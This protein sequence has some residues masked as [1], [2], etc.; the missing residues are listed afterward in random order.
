MR[1]V[2]ENG[3]HPG[4]PTRARYTK[5]EFRRSRRALPRPLRSRPCH[6][7][8]ACSSPAA[9]TRRR[10]DGGRAGHAVPGRR[11]KPRPRAAAPRRSCCRRR[12]L[13]PRRCPSLDKAENE[14]D[15]NPGAKRP[16]E[17]KP[18]AEREAAALPAGKA[19][20]PAAAGPVLAKTTEP[21]GQ[22]A[23]VAA[24]QVAATPK[25]AATPPAKSVSLGPPGRRHPRGASSQRRCTAGCRQPP[26]FRFAI[27][28]GHP[29]A[30][31]GGRGRAGTHTLL[32]APPGP[33]PDS[34]KCGYWAQALVAGG[35]GERP[36]HGAGASEA[37][38]ALLAPLEGAIEAPVA[39]VMGS[40]PALTG[41][42]DGPAPAA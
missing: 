32:R 3:D 27:G 14:E 25:V 6:R 19:T 15:E 7:G 31:R 26:P 9:R 4:G 36:D 30:G 34:G 16:A 20:V 28:P 24:T 22:D 33:H 2:F 37:G 5:L 29:R 10:R 39:A 35:T 11:A 23:K 12:W 17:E 1:E 40:P 21:L 42:L 13:C 38:I 41:S 8:F 18:I